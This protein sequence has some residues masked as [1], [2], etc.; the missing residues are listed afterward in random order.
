MNR[1]FQLKTVLLGAAIL[2]AFAYVGGILIAR[3]RLSDLQSVL[4]VQIAD[5][6][7]LLRTIAETTA[8]NGADTV[9]EDVV[10][11]CAVDERTTFDELLGKLDT[12]LNKSDLV[13][14]ERLFG[15]C[16]SF[17]A[18]RKSLMVARLNREVEVYE[19]YVAQLNEIGGADVALYKVSL[20]KDLASEEKKQSEAFSALVEH[21]DRIISSLIDGKSATSPEIKIILDQVKEVQ[22]VLFE[23]NN[24]AAE[25]RKELIS[26]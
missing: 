2:L 25:K 16:G 17:Y 20:W 1:Q 7:G 12:G 5:Q 24:A 6:Q 11:D 3:E 21:Q 18:E 15:R 9:T 26:L 13:T 23:A 4:K 8:R 14:L 10:K 19:N 22:N